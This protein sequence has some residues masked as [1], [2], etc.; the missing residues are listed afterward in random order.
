MNLDT[1]RLRLRPFALADAADCFAFLSDAETCRLDGGYEPFAAMDDEYRRLMEKFAAQPD[2][3]VVVVKETEHV[4]GMIHVMPDE[5]GRPDTLELGYVSSP[6][7]RRKGYM[8]EAVRAVMD[9]LLQTG[10]KCLILG[11]ARSN[12]PS[13]RMAEKLGFT[14]AGDYP[15]VLGEPMAQYEYHA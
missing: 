14:P 12:T 7:H 6:F 4:I 9:H 3:T 2:R 11:I 1:P 10:T 5:Q 8:S 13:L 15:P